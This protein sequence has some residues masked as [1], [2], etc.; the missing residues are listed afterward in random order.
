MGMNWYHRVERRYVEYGSSFEAT[1]TF[2][3][4]RAIYDTVYNMNMDHLSWR[5]RRSS[6]ASATPAC[7]P[8]ARRS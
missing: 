8:P 3:L 7:A 1:R 4:F 6:S 5:R 2:G